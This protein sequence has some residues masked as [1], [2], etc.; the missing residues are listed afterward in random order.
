MKRIKRAYYY[1][2]HTNP[3]TGYIHL[4]ITK[5]KRPKPVFKDGALRHFRVNYGSNF[6]KQKHEKSH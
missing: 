6:R 2:Y 3:P 4:V 5:W 1:S